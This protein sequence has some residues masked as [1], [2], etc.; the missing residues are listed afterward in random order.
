MVVGVII[1]KQEPTLDHLL[2]AMCTSRHLIYYICS[3]NSLNLI[4]NK[5]SSP[6]I[7]E[8]IESQKLTGHT[9]KRYK[10]SPW[11]TAESIGKAHSTCSFCAVLHRLANLQGMQPTVFSRVSA[12]IVLLLLFMIM[13]VLLR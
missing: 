11:M 5:H 12:T 4:L 2:G 3:V 13:I 9:N 8:E 1:V 6:L 7:N 10:N